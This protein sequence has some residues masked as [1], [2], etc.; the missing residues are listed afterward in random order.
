LQNKQPGAEEAFKILGR[1][2]KII[3]APV[4]TSYL[5]HQIFLFDMNTYL[6]GKI[7]LL[8]NMDL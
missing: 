4:S 2:F 1:A 3:G 7:L 8:K 6:M 5:I